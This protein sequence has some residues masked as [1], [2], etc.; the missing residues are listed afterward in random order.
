MDVTDEQWELLRELIVEPPRRPDKKGRP[1]VKPR[2]ILNG[3]LWILRTGAPWKD[4]PDRYPSYQTCHRR[5]Q[6]WS[7]NGTLKNTLRALAQGLKDRGDLNLEEAFIDGTF[8]PA[9]KGGLCVGKTKRG[10][11]TKIMAIAEHSGLPVACCVESA[12]PHEVTLVEQTLDACVVDE[13]PKRLI[14]DK[15]YDSDPIDEK[16]AKERGVELIAPH[17]TNRKKPATQDGRNLRRYLRRWKVE[18]LFAWL[19]NFRRLVVRYEWRFENFLGFLH[20]GCIV[21]LLRYF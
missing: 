15:A 14:G 12:S 9:K 10:K 3:I 6:E 19:Q 2:P 21:I 18:R 17:R 4:L 1:R 20:L 8:V 7:L 5:F 13:A 16:L 11:G